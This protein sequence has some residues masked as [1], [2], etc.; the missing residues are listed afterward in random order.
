MPVPVLVQDHY[1]DVA[2]VVVV[3]V[4]VL[5]GERPQQPLPRCLWLRVQLEPVLP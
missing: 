3:A 1:L 4:E 5:L 2:V